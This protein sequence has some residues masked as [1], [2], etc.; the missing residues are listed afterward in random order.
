[1]LAALGGPVLKPKRVGAAGHHVVEPQPLNGGITFC[2][3]RVVA[4]Q[5]AIGPAT[6]CVTR[7]I[8]IPIIIR[9]L[10]IQSN[11]RVCECSGGNATCLLAGRGDTVI[12][13]EEYWQVKGIVDCAIG[14][15]ADSYIPSP[16]LS[17]VIIYDDADL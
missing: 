16:G 4:L 12:C 1:M 15:N 2:I 13:N 11:V 17:D 6:A 7:R 10:I 14:C 3:R 5:V 9:A 8:S